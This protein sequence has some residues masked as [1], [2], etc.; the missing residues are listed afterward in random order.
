[1][2]NEAVRLLLGADGQL[3]S[4]TDGRAWDGDRIDESCIEVPHLV[5][6]AMTFHIGGPKGSDVVK[7]LVRF[8]CHCWSSKWED[9]HS[10]ASF[11][12]MDG[13]RER[14]FDPARFEASLELPALIR[15]LPEIQVYVTRTELRLLLRRSPR[16][17]ARGIHRPLYDASAERPVQRNPPHASPAGGKRLSAYP[18]GTRKVQDKPARDHCR[19]AKG[20]D[21]QVPFPVKHQGSLSAPWLPRRPLGATRPTCATAQLLVRIRVSIHP[22][23][24]TASRQR[25]GSRSRS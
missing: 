4:Q 11:R 7:A 2:A 10:S 18:T 12:I 5:P 8:S 20:N 6:H 13:N 22:C 19:R 1:M 16:R 14:A 9:R 3:R 25:E 23:G 15:A 17:C 24:L 21:C